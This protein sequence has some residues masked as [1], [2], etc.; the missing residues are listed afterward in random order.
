MSGNENV[1]VTNVL[2]VGF[3]FWTQNCISWDLPPPSPDA[4]KRWNSPEHVWD[5][6]RGRGISGRSADGSATRDFFLARS[7]ES[8]IIFSDDVFPR[9][10]EVTIVVEPDDIGLANTELTQSIATIGGRIDVKSTKGFLPPELGGGPLLVG[11]EWISFNGMTED[12][13][14]IKRRGLRQ[15]YPTS[16]PGG[17]TVKQGMTFVYYIPISAGYG[18]HS[19]EKMYNKHIESLRIY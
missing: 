5:S 9:M 16:H 6:T 15:S 7:R 10:V 11:D 18:N 17:T 14:I 4:S 1:T 3:R 8:I 12:A 2:Y 13:F 19:T